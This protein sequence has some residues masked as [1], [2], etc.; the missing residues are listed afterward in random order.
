MNK[1]SIVVKLL[2]LEN[3]ARKFSTG[4]P[5]QDRGS[6]E[7]VST[8]AQ[9]SSFSKSNSDK[10][11]ASSLPFVEDFILEHSFLGVPTSWIEISGIF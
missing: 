3:H 10:P 2:L 7:P 6:S 8:A 9:R 4:N 5:S 1:R 11:S